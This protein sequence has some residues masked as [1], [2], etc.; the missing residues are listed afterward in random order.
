VF[1]DATDDFNWKTEIMA[2][3]GTGKTEV[4][5]LANAST[6]TFSP[7]SRRLAYVRF[8][9][10]SRI[11][12][13]DLAGGDEVRLSPADPVTDDN[14]SW[15]GAA[16][17][18]IAFTTEGP[19]TIWIMNADGTGRTKLMPDNDPLFHQP[20]TVALSPDGLQVAFTC[21]PQVHVY[22]ICIINADG[23]GFARLTDADGNDKH[24]RWTRDGRI[25][26][27]SERDGNKEIYIMNADG[28]EQTNLT[29]SAADESPFSP[30]F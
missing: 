13:S 23:T 24:P 15:A 1:I 2:V 12:T 8:N 20:P 3:D 9:P 19:R 17:G 16:P 21:Q 6:P 18:R 11:L 22:D 28:S 5:P 7:N 10:G 14:P 26:F 4:L 25:V 30:T 27:S 29:T